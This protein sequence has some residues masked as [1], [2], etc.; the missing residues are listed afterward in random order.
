MSGQMWLPKG[1]TVSSWSMA[2]VTGQFFN[3]GTQVR[4]S[5]KYFGKKKSLNFGDYSRP[6][7]D[8]SRQLNLVCDDNSGWTIKDI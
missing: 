2:R 1:Q 3:D 7:R 8:N 4:Y 5:K 6:E